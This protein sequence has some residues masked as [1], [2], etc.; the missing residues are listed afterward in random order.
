MRPGWADKLAGILPLS[1]KFLG[2]N[3][4][5]QE[6]SRHFETEMFAFLV[7]EIKSLLRH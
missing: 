1:L 7:S 5:E 2:K 6:H 3:S 4:C